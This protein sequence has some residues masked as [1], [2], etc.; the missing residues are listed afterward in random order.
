VKEDRLDER[1]HEAAREYN[2]PPPTPRERMWARIADERRSRPPA[3][4][5]LRRSRRIWYP[6]AAAAVLLL[7]I[8]I[9]RWGLNPTLPEGGPAISGQPADRS[10]Q[11]AATTA[12]GAAQTGGRDEISV[13]RY[14]AAPVLS[15]AELLL[16]QFQARRAA[17]GDDA[18]FS[19][20][21]AALLV[22]TRLLLDS[23]AAE[24]PELRML[25]GDLELVLARIVRLAAQQEEDER[26][27]AEQGLAERAILPRLRANIPVGPLPFSL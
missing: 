1:L 4:P 14:A 25:L 24:N 27:W 2:A 16:T 8:A 18:D 19:S 10:R 21:A 7:G 6:V 9:G 26:V 23:P 11:R 3:R 5:S 20:R 22:E 17:T 12:T 13:Y 15:K